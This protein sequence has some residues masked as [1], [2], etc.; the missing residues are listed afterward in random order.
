MLHPDHTGPRVRVIVNTD[1]K[2]EADDQFA[3]VH[4]ALTPSFDLV[5][6]TA[7]H[8]GDKKHPQSMLESRK[9]IDLLVR[10]LGP[11]GQRFPVSNGA[12]HAIPDERTPVPSEGADLIV[13]EALRDDTEAPLYVTFYGPLTDMASALLIAP[14]IAERPIVVIWIGGGPYPAGGAEYNL[15]NDIAAA[16]VVF[17]S[18]V[19]LWQVP[20]DVYRMMAVGYAEMM[21]RV[22]PYGELGKYLVDQVVEYNART[23]PVR[24]E[25]RSWGDSPAVGLILNPVGGQSDLVPA[26][27]F[28]DDM[29]YVHRDTDRRVRAFR[30]I[31]QRYILEDF[32]SKLRLWH[33]G[34]L[35]GGYAD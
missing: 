29:T 7:A 13:R 2:N 32:F 35:F 28:A 11:A 23:R 14:Q 16:N 17:D 19:E 24:W 5:G 21:L 9:E 34:D 27:R 12:T 25:Y 26:P 15:S 3:I 22:Y 30:S 6:V 8:Y 4:A 20:Q 33:E 18:H 10:L 31:D 1:A